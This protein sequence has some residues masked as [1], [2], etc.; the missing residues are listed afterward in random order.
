MSTRRSWPTTSPC[1]C[2]S[3][4]QRPEP[5]CTGR[6]RSSSLMACRNGQRQ[7]RGW[8]PSPRVVS[9]R[10]TTLALGLSIALVVGATA[11][12]GLPAQVAQPDAVAHLLSDLQTALASGD[13]TRLTAL[14]SPALSPD[15]VNG[16][17]H[18][19]VAGPDATVMVRERARRPTA[20]GTEVL[21]DIF[22]G[23]RQRAR[24]VTWRIHTRPTGDGRAIIADL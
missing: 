2:S 6:N 21:A 1:W 22:L 23:H 4:T 20:E 9:M 24:V 7:N 11:A 12:I 14:E 8:E 13:A 5:A 17:A 15:T 18:S 16:I 19:V 3:D 10:R